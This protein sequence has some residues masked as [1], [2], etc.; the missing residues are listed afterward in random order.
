MSPGD[1]IV[2]AVSEDL[3]VHDIRFSV[4]RGVA[5]I[6]PGNLACDSR[7]LGRL[8]SENKIIRLDTNPRLDSKVA[9]QPRVNSPEPLVAPPID[10]P[11]VIELRTQLQKTLADFKASILEIQKLRADLEA[12]RTECGQLLADVSKLRAEVIRLKEEDAKL[13]TILGKLDNLPVSVGVQ[14]STVVAPS[15]IKVEDGAELEPEMPVFI[16]SSVLEPPKSSK[17]MTARESTFDGSRVNESV[18]T[19]KELRKKKGG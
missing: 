11:E 12:S 3:V 15:E 19:L 16:S 9:T 13:S 10:T 7:D 18:R 4:P 2:Q 8:M 17:K 5:T 1:M 14:T 6:I